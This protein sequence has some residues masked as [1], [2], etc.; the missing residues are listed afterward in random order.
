MSST[1]QL[2]HDGRQP[3][4]LRAIKIERGFTL[5]AEGSV[6]ISFGETRVLCNAS[7]EEK[8]P[9]FMRGQG[10]GWPPIFSGGRICEVVGGGL[11]ALLALLAF[12]MRR[13]GETTSRSAD[14][15]TSTRNP[16]YL[17]SYW[18]EHIRTGAPQRATGKNSGSSGRD[19][20]ACQMPKVPKGPKGCPGQATTRK[21]VPPGRGFSP[22]ELE[23]VQRIGGHHLLRCDNPR[24]SPPRLP[25]G[26]RETVGE[27]SVKPAD[28]R[29]LDPVGS[30]EVT[31]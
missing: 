14:I 20:H 8:V 25:L 16:S 11:L 18:H 9:P 4:Q 29:L 21:E 13:N 27:E 26:D 28:F 7:V 30:A 12:G 3:N 6:L 2:R 24:R 19:L 5:Y 17:H 31:E 1:T 22:S 10:R 23:P 15:N